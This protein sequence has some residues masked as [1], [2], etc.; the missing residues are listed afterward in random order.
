MS[1]IRSQLTPKCTATSRMVMRRDQLQGVAL[2]GLGVAPP[3]VGEGDL[4]LSHHATRL[5][6]DAW[7]GQDHECRA[8]ADGQ[9][10]EAAFDLTA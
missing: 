1:L 2:E 3:R 4:D 9:G 7:D 6:F 8:T 5:T 10:P